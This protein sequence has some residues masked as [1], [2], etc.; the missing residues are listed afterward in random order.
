MASPNV[1]LVRSIYA[2][3][4]RGDFSSAAWADPEIEYVDADGTQPGTWTGLAGMAEGWRGWLMGWKDVRVMA[5][6]YI[7]LDEGR[8][9]VIYRGTGAGRTSGL[10][11]EQIHPRGGATLF[12]IRDG[13]VTRLV[14]YFDRERALADVGVA[15]EGH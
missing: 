2:A 8:V 6:E 11:V 12:H 10:R 15:P 3:W 5:A 1:E 7:E 9:L 14:V 4:E 13:R